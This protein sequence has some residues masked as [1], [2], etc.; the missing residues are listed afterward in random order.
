MF[1]Q[2]N[3]FN[4]SVTTI[5][6]S[7]AGNGS[8]SM[9]VSGTTAG[10]SMTYLLYLYP[11]IDTPI[12]QTSEDTF[13]NL[14]SGNYLVQAIQ[15]LG[16]LQNTQ[17]ANADIDNLITVLDFEIDQGFTG[18]C[19]DP[20]IFVTTL[21][22]NAE[23]YE[24]L[25]G[26]VTAPLQMGNTFADLPIGTYVIRVF[27]TCGNALTKTY[28]LL[29]IDVAFSVTAV[30]QPAVLNSCEET[31]ISHVITAGNGAVLS[32]PLSVNY[33]ISLLDGSESTSFS[34]TYESGPEMEL[35]ITEIVA[36]YD[37]QIFQIEIV[38]EDDC[39]DVVTNTEVINPNPQVN[40][41]PAS[42]V[43]GMN[44]IITVS[45]I[46][47]P[48]TLEFIDSPMG[49][50]PTDYNDN[51]DGV[52]TELAISFE[53]EDI[54]LPYGTYSVRV[55]D[56]C[57]R[58]GMATIDLIE[59]PIEPVIS[60]TNGG[61]DPLIGALNVSIPEREIVSAIFTLAPEAYE[62]D[63]P[64]DISD[65]II[66]DGS[67]NISELPK[68]TYILEMIDNCGTVY[69]E[70]IIIPDLADLPIN[71]VA[72]P[73]CNFDTGALRIAGSYGIIESVFIIDAPAAFAET[74]PFDY[75]EAI[76]PGGFF[77]VDSLPVG[78]YDIEFTDSCGNEFMF[79][80]TIASYM[81]DPSI[82]N[83]Q[84]NC[85]SFDL[86]I[87][88]TDNSVTNQSY[89]LQ[90]YYPANDAWGN[91]NTGVIYTEGE[92]P[93]A[94]NSMTIQN[95][96]I[97]L[98]IFV[99]G[100]FRLIKAFQSVNSPNPD[101]FCLDIF[102]EFDIGSDLIIDDVYNL[103]C[104]GGS[105]PSDILVDVIGVP[106]YN[107]SIVSPIVIDN[108]TDNIFTD[109][110]P[111]VYDIRVE[112][113]C[114]SIEVIT[115]NLLDL[116]P[117]VNIGNPEDLVT[118]SD[119]L[120]NQ[121]VFNLAQQNAQ[122]LG[123][124]NPE[125]LIITYHLTQSDAD[126]G[127]NPIS[128]SYENVTNPQTVYA[129]MIHNT[130]DICYETTSFQLIVGLTPQLGPDEFITICEDS[131]ILLSA[132][133]GYSSYLWSTGESTRIITVND[134]GTYSVIVSNDYGDFNCEATKTFTLDVS[135]VATI[136]TVVT[137]DFTSNSNSISIEVSGLGDYEYSLDGLTYQPEPVFTNL[138]SGVYTIFVRDIN[139]CGVSTETISLLNYK[140]FFTPN[141][142]NDND[143][144]QITGS[145]FEPNLQVYIYNRYG[146]LLISFS[147]DQIG[148]DGSYNGKIMPT[149]DYWFVVERENGLT[150]TGHFTLK[151]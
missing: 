149:N 23:S 7:C 141:E 77:Y 96:E 129:R 113:V 74:L 50:D 136:D 118:C 111:G 33:T 121:A 112:D 67:L 99:V 146:K 127:N 45:S 135:G 145:Q 150:H 2:L 125:N 140:K 137:E 17:S 15:T 51:V 132:E 30:E 61:C 88:D 91:P 75:S 144:W 70:E 95:G 92:L 35:E 131:T 38:V 19:N 94:S 148:W 60:A 53:Q 27:D 40:M 49:F 87:D 32:Y 134:P 71:V 48:Y 24:I 81:S 57:G 41:T 98:N 34:Q 10:A 55:V 4:F 143:Y 9:T 68:G 62:N 31:T 21:S 103:N 147:G 123:N 28:T 3:D 29:L 39:G 47:P 109:L 138:E 73:S 117:V 59:E 1:A 44:L 56:S 12:A 130:L 106:P 97:V 90:K 14:G 76:L 100:T 104:D 108:G 114:G 133:P 20:S 11:D 116:L 115:V 101:E 83:V 110:S 128:E 13:G 126:S 63:T 42:T 93:N 78:N 5:D 79:N 85:G 89:W 139:G 16:E 105:G 86:F 119:E 84:R 151:R 58:I 26:P 37:D 54:G 107:F 46:I 52:Y 8:I 43:C 120:E 22:G 69:V 122:L 18:E 65:F 102:A 64:D 82:Y 36:N 80:Q 66:S 25:S 142:D 72:S 6:E 124:Q